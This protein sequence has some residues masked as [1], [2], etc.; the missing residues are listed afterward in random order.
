MACARRTRCAPCAR[1]LVL[2]VALAAA[3]VWWWRRRGA[4]AGGTATVPPSWP[5]LADA[6]AADGTG[7]RPF[8]AAPGDVVTGDVVTGDVVTG[9]V[10]TGDADAGDADAGGGEPAGARW[11]LPVAGQ[12]PPGY[13][14]KANDNSGIFHV[15]G[16]RFYA[17]TVPERCYAESADAVADGY[18]QA[19]A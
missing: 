16:G 11:V 17:R 5:P 14:V 2:L 18:R 7:L 12:C 1:R 10:V 4:V 15:P 6:V 13:P 8:V 3:A 19:K 9:D